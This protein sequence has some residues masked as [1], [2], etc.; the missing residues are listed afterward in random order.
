LQIGLHPLTEILTYILYRTPVGLVGAMK[1]LRVHSRM[2]FQARQEMEIAHK[3]ANN[4]DQNSRKDFFHYIFRG[5]DTE[6]GSKYTQAELFSESNLL[7]IAGSDTTA[8]TLAAVFF[9]LLR[10]PGILRTLRSEIEEK[11][12]S[13]DDIKLAEVSGS[14]YLRAVIDETLRL[15]P[16]VPGSPPREVLSG[17]IQVDG[18]FIPE[19]AEVGVPFYAIHHSPEYFSEPFAFRPERWIVNEKQGVTKTDVERAQN[20]F[21]PFNI[22]HRGCIG[23][24]LAYQELTLA[25]ARVVMRYDF[26]EVKGWEASMKLGGWKERMRELPSGSVASRSNPGL[27]DDVEGSSGAW[28]RDGEFVIKDGFAAIRDGPVVKFREKRLQRSMHERV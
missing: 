26:Q 1:R 6:T 25:I 15:A 13:V 2:A 24:N 4:N 22:G 8:T 28:G 17:G 18:I 11:C 20:A 14:P 5:T 23:K 16:P 7:L 3:K 21:M 19:G 12:S 9:Y 27:K 10:H